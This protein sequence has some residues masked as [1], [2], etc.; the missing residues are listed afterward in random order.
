VGC[1]SALVG[2]HCAREGLV[3]RTEPAPDPALAAALG[4]QPG[5]RVALVQAVSP[6]TG[7]TH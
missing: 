2:E 6:P 1:V 7:A 4:L 3:V 5:W